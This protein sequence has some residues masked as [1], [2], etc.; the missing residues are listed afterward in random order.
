MVKTLV[1]SLKIA[2]FTILLTGILYPL[3]VTGMSTIFFYK[4]ATGSLVEN[5]QGKIVGSLLIGQTFKNP[6]YFF[7]R[8]SEAEKG[9]EGMLSGASNLAPTSKKLI[10]K[11]HERSLKIRA[12]NDAPIP[13]DLVTASA[14]GLDPHISLQAAY[15]QAPRIALKREVTLKR[16]TSIIDDQAQRFSLPNML[17]NPYLNVLELNLLLDQFFGPPMEVK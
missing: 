4:Q 16:I 15:W 14:S 6:A 3:L 13:I 9:Y 8:P 2:L 5:G 10:E 11:I 17:S 12:M 7:S 1:T